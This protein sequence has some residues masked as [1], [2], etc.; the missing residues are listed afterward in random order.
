MT[1]I[2]PEPLNQENPENL[3]DEPNDEPGLLNDAI[4]DFQPRDQNLLT[5]YNDID[6]VSTLEELK[7]AQDFISYLQVASFDHDGL[8]SEAKAQLKDPITEPINLEADP[9]LRVGIYIFLDTTNASDKTYT[10]V[11]NSVNSYI[12]HLGIDPEEHSIPTLHSV[13]KKIGQL[14][15]I[16]SIM[17]DMCPKTCIAY[18]GPYSSLNQ[19]PECETP[20]HNPERLAASSG[21]N[22]IPQRQFYT[23]PLGPQIQALWRN[24]EGAKAMRHHVIETA[25]T[26]Q[27]NAGEVYNESMTSI[28][29]ETISMLLNLAELLKM[30]WS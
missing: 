6:I 3:D 23:I 21:R 1:L 18:T 7:T 15:G 10:D 25:K 24:P 29:G 13:K 16:H 5:E 14:T 8:D 4:P 9:D 12:E 30:T 20:R 11:R 26:Q 17:T 28:L 2:P 27:G 22:K 19:C